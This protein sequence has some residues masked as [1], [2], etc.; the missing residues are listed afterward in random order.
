MFYFAWN[1]T[2]SGGFFDTFKNK[3]LLPKLEYLKIYLGS[4]LKIKI[5]ILRLS[6]NCGII[7]K[8]CVSNLNPEIFCITRR[9]RLL[10]QTTKQQL[11]N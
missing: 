5:E 4:N 7:Y 9:H 10:G 3:A 2:F 11:R 6:E 8:K 1:A